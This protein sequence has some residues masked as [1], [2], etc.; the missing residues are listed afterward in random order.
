MAGGTVPGALER[1]DILRRAKASMRK[2]TV[3]QASESE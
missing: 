1:D 3:K 2:L